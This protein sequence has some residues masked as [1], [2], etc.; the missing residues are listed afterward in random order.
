MKR[1]PY[2]SDLTDDQWEFICN[3]PRFTHGYFTELVKES[4]REIINAWFYRWETGIPWRMMPHDLPAPATCARHHKL[5]KDDE[6]LSLLRM[7]MMDSTKYPAKPKSTSQ[8]TVVEHA[9][10]LAGSEA[11]LSKPR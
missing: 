6:R 10:N 2:P 1:R 11:F 7:C 4:L 9:I 3:Y 5:W 8:R